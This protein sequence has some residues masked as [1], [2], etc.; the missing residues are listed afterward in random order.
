M[1][2]LVSFFA[3]W[4]ASELAPHL[5]LQQVAISLALVW[6]GALRTP[7]GW[8][9]L[10]LGVASWAMFWVPL[11]IAFIRRATAARRFLEQSGYGEAERQHM[12]GDASSRSYERLKLNGKSFILMNWILISTCVG[13]SN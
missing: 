2:P 10:A 3:G 5:F 9:A 12:M 6:L 1:T 8:G 7:L 4:L 13:I 11:R